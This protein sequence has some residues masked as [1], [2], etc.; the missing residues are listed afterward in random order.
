LRNWKPFAHFVLLLAAAACNDRSVVANDNLVGGDDGTGDQPPDAPRMVVPD[1]PPPMPDAFTCSP[2]D[3]YH[4]RC[5]CTAETCVP[6][7]MRWCD[8]VLTCAWG[9]QTCG[10]DGAWGKCAE[11]M[12]K[13]AGCTV[14][15][16]DIGC[17]IRSGDCCE[18]RDP[19]NNGTSLGTCPGLVQECHPL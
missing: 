1:A 7:S 11:V 12:T 6:G 17:C 5:V 16:Y 9:Q 14:V 19:G 13:P 15:N 8:S 4:G 3:E 10:P 2:D 18:S